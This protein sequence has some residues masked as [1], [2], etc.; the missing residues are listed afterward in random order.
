MRRLEIGNN[1]VN[2]SSE[3]HKHTSPIAPQPHQ[4]KEQKNRSRKV[5]L[6]W[7]SWKDIKADREKSPIGGKQDMK[8]KHRVMKRDKKTQ[9][10]R[11]AKAMAQQA[12][13]LLEYDMYNL[14]TKAV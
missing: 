4:I 11:A 12:L 1:L 14:Q 2:A 10:R 8:D 9:H 3:T 5:R 13:S 6:S 7:R